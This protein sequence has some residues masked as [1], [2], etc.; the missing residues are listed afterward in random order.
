MQQSQSCASLSSQLHRSPFADK[1]LLR[2]VVEG[3]GSCSTLQN[4]TKAKHQVVNLSLG[5]AF[6]GVWVCLYPTD[7]GSGALWS[8]R[9][10]RSPQ[11]AQSH[12]IHLDTN[13]MLLIAFDRHPKRKCT[14]SW[15]CPYRLH[16]RNSNMWLPMSV[17][18]KNVIW[19][20]HSSTLIR[21]KWT[22]G[23][24]KCILQLFVRRSLHTYHQHYFPW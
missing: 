10:P 5:C 14:F 15:Q 9:I 3:H 16:N 19:S 12:S 2:H 22:Q 8:Q 6:G 20:L 17:C 21:E 1:L 24:T 11:R 4:E 18:S 13:S 7:V 23:V